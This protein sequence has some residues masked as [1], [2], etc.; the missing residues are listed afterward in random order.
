MARKIAVI[1]G[2]TGSIGS[3]I[4]R[5]FRSEGYT[6]ILISRTSHELVPRGVYL[7]NCDLND[8]RQIRQTVSEIHSRFTHIDA[9]VNCA[10]INRN[11]D[12]EQLNERDWYDELHTNINGAVFLPKLLLETMS[13]GSTIVNISSIKA[14]EP[15]TSIAYGASK[16]ALNHITINLAHQL[17]G[18][19]IRVNAVAPGYINTPML[20]K[21][22]KKL[23]AQRSLLQRLGRSE[24]VANI[25]FFLCSEES[26][27]INGQ[28]IRA[29][30]GI[31]L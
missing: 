10:G 21:T 20:N 15:T 13:R 27:L 23:Y 16:A 1:T 6:V 24:E 22:K 12:L 18:R 26:S 2:G 4:A 28:V 31:F 14:F 7:Y 30:G 3:A 25:V 5:R 9:L 8:V 19:G 29:D 17:S 11:K